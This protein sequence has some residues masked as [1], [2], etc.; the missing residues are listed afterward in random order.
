MVDFAACIC[1]RTAYVLTSQS[2]SGSASQHGTDISSTQ[3]LGTG[4]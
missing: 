3:G 2:H 4:P 1:V